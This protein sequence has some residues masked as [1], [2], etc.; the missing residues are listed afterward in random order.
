VNSGC[1]GAMLAVDFNEDITSP[2]LD[3]FNLDMDQGYLTMHFLEVV[4]VESVDVEEITLLNT[5][6]SAGVV[7]RKL[8]GG[9]K[10]TDA[11]DDNGNPVDHVRTFRIKLEEV[12]L[13]NLKF[14]GIGSSRSTSWLTMTASTLVDA[15]DR[16]VQKID[17]PVQVD[18]TGFEADATPPALR[19]YTVSM[20]SG[21]LELSFAESVNPDSVVVAAFTLYGGDSSQQIYVPPM[22]FSATELADPATWCGNACNSD[23]NRAQCNVGCTSGARPHQSCEQHCANDAACIRGC[24]LRKPAASEYTLTDGSVVVDSR[25]D[26][27]IVVI[28]ISDTDMNE[29]KLRDGL[30]TEVST[31]LLTIDGEGGENGLVGV[32]D[33]LGNKIQTFTNEAALDH[34]EDI[35]RPSMTSF[36][37]DLTLNTFTLTFDETIFEMPVVTAITIQNTRVADVVDSALAL[38]PTTPQSVTLTNFDSA[39]RS[40][41]GLVLTIVANNDDLNLLKY[42]T[43]LCVSQST[44]YIVIASGAFK[45]MNNRPVIDIA[46]SNAKMASKFFHDTVSPVL[47]SFK[48]DLTAETLTLYFS[49]T[50][51]SS[52]LKVETISFFSDTDS[53][54]LTDKSA[55]ASDNSATIVVDLDT[56]DLNEIKYKTGLAT[57]E[58]NLKIEVTSVTIDDMNLRDVVAV[59][60]PI[61]SGGFEED[62]TDP[63]LVNYDL[64]LTA[65]TLTMTFDE[66]V[67][68]S[69]L[70]VNQIT[71]QSHR[72]TATNGAT[73]YTLSL[74]SA[75]PSDDSTVIVIALD[76]SDLNAI[77]LDRG[78]ASEAG[79]TFLRLTT[80]AIEDMNEG[81]VVAIDESD[82]LPVTV[83]T[84]DATPPTLVTFGVDMTEGIVKLVF[85]E[86]VSWAD[87]ILRNL[88]FLAT[89]HTSEVVASGDVARHKLSPTYEEAVT[90]GNF[91]TLEDSTTIYFK[92]TENDFDE[93]KRKEI[94]WNANDCHIRLD[95]G[96]IQDMSLPANEI[97]RVED[98]SKVTVDA[99]AYSPDSVRPYLENFEVNMDDMTL[100]LSF[101]EP[102]RTNELNFDEITMQT[103][104]LGDNQRTLVGGTTNDL[105]S[106]VVVVHFD[107]ADSNAIKENTNMCTGVF[108]CWIIITEDV[109]N[110]LASVPNAL[111]PI[112]D[113]DVAI[114]DNSMFAAVF[115]DDMT[116]PVLEQFD[117]DLTLNTLTL[118]FTESVDA[119]TLDVTQITISGPGGANPVPLTGNGI[120]AST[121]PAPT[122][123]Y[124]TLPELQSSNADELE[125]NGPVVVIA[126]GFADANSLKLREE[127][128]TSATNT[129]ISV[130]NDA[131]RDM[132]RDFQGKGNKILSTNG[133]QLEASGGEFKE[134][135]VNPVLERF[136]LDLDQATLSL[137][138]S[139][140]ILKSSINVGKITLHGIDGDY[141]LTGASALTEYVESIEANGILNVDSTR[142]FY[143]DYIVDV[144]LGRADINAISVVKTM[145][146]EPSNTFVS[147]AVGTTEDMNAKPVDANAML[148]AFE[149]FDDKTSPKLLDFDVDMNAGTLYMRM[150]ESVD[151]DSIKTG[152]LMITNGYQAVQ[153]DYESHTFT[154]EPTDYV[155]GSVVQ[156]DPSRSDSANGAEFTLTIGRKDLNVL[157]RL[158]DTAINA[159]KTV[160]IFDAPFINDMHG[161]SVELWQEH[162]RQPAVS[163]TPDST[164]PVLTTFDIDLDQGLLYLNFDETIPLTSF[165]SAAAITLHT[166]AV[167]G[168][169]VDVTLSADSKLVSDGLPNSAL[170]TVALSTLDLWRIKNARD[171]LATTAAGYA[172]VAENAVTD[173]VG[174]SNAAPALTAQNREVVHD[175]ERPILQNFKVDLVSGTIALSF[176]EPVDP[177]SVNMGGAVFQAA[178]ATQPSTPKKMLS[179]GTGVTAATG[180]LLTVSMTDDDMTYLQRE[181]ELLHSV[182]DTYLAFDTTILDDMAVPANDVTPINTNSAMPASDY[183]YYDYAT[184]SNIG[185]DSGNPSGGTTV[186]ITGSGFVQKSL[187]D[188]SRSPDVPLPVAVFVNNVQA[189]D[190]VV[191]DDTELTFSTPAVGDMTL[192]DQQLGVEVLIDNALTTASM[193]FTYLNPPVLE[194]IRPIAGSLN[195]GTLVTM[196]GQHF[197]KDA[198]TGGQA[199]IK[200]IFGDGETATTDCTVVN[201]DAI[202]KSPAH[203]TSCGAAWPEDGSQCIV[204]VTLSVD[205]ALTS[206][207]LVFEYL[208]TPTLLAMTPTA[209]YFDTETPVSV[210]GNN[211]GALT[212]TGNT[213]FVTLLVGDRACSEGSVEVVA[214]TD[215][216]I[217][218]FGLPASTEKFT[219]LIAKG[220]GPAAV[221]VSIDGTVSS[222]EDF[223]F[224]DYNDAG[225]FTF[226]K[227]THYVHES[228]RTVELAISRSPSDHPSPATLTITPRGWTDSDLVTPGIS[229]TIFGGDWYTDGVSARPPVLTTGG[230]A[231]TDWHDGQN[232]TVHFP[233]NVFHATFQFSMTGQTRLAPEGRNG[234]A[235]DGAILLDITN[236]D[237]AHGEGHTVGVPSTILVESECQSGG[238]Y[239]EGAT[240]FP[241]AMFTLDNGD[242]IGPLPD[243]ANVEKIYSRNLNGP[244]CAPE[245][246][247]NTNVC[248]DE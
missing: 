167:L 125:P 63:T 136:S 247:G 204:D 188:T 233:E 198:S 82:A 170:L 161:N 67:E 187:R 210:F 42:N 230:A 235:S 220:H 223:T 52:T 12:D 84:R 227:V 7:S 231:D 134:D 152:V 216:D 62:A 51:M 165:T 34:A 193:G 83:Y 49:E 146:T 18:E 70:A 123:G 150:S 154:S 248:Y 76:I 54:Q 50:V 130:T 156:S 15:N 8:T 101:S 109:V 118:T 1:G 85:D 74:K 199:K 172:T 111:E 225:E 13:N 87:L 28:Q 128:A 53:F 133:L 245:L 3:H 171:L 241:M 142:S 159:E 162:A 89:D 5:V 117:L 217:V 206:L 158:E 202:C 94:C 60:M 179:A 205:G 239:C 77:K 92:F 177:Q 200:A 126:L 213:P 196:T 243:L 39:T 147:I 212:A 90:G 176:N 181:L 203:V 131:V 105:N 137:T 10:S 9:V 6:S 132:Y 33:T 129:Y 47:N 75:T 151:I 108:N 194:Q 180:T 36:E 78:L 69:S 115:F 48:V 211:F 232:I 29:I 218:E 116:S 121:R 242:V 68:S 41:D 139:E 209:G 81:K 106:R 30:A 238:Y 4:S 192:T 2:R 55:T 189:S 73:Q 102:V 14:N 24:Y 80:S 168:A 44:T 164:P 143:N 57:S 38:G 222:V 58:S 93:M 214:P 97:E 135:K 86:T 119:K 31:T 112:A 127:M 100:T 91:I 226:D 32:K 99:T 148:Q 104:K 22:S 186:T 20:N 190:V 120:G 71:L 61:S 234:H 19:S 175:T 21:L 17:Y 26:D 113:S 144:K 98:D 141:P 195:G 166:G 208:P 110:D 40:A 138:F 35:T 228:V 96:A 244:S 45:D 95:E 173:M 72:N 183:L 16:P 182:D 66:T 184:V 157:K 174:D 160:L 59:Q 149:V 221:H 215:E 23:A 240:I 191:V 46:D 140:I 169:G 114:V 124:K 229:S 153:A 56:L 224:V 64:D 178:E 236:V 163:Y 237:A 219:C 25:A 103:F 79:T 43:E 37:V 155:V 122:H 107:R 65:E 11:V 145:G 197:G 207:D 88:E 246:D 27:T 185:P 201:G